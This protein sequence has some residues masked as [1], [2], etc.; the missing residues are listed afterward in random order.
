MLIRY[1]KNIE[2][3]AMGLLSFMPT[4]KDVK[5]LQQI[6]KEYDTNPNWHLHLWKAEDDMIGVIG[7]QVDDDRL[8]AVI[9]HVAVS[10]SHR[11][12][13]IGKKMIAEI[14]QQ[15]HN[16]HIWAEAEIDDFYNKCCDDVD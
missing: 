13:G 3:I 2:K 1:K 9:Q 5:T 4:V 6:I 14:N 10:P 15:Y 7:L 16:Y 8:E 11:N 12:Q